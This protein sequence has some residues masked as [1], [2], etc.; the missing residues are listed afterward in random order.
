MTITIP[1]KA[2]KEQVKEAISKLG[3]KNKKVAPRKGNAAKFFGANPN[4]ADGMSFQ[5][6]VRKEWN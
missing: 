6:K 4:E 1:K 2:S 5:K 3:K